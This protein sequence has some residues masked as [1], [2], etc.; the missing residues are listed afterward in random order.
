MNPEATSY[1]VS[2]IIFYPFFVVPRV[3]LF[4]DVVKLRCFTAA[5]YFLEIPTWDVSH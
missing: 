1:S 5:I 3:C 2:E 4:Y